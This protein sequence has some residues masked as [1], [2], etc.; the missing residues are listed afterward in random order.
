MVPGLGAANFSDE[1]PDSR[2]AT[3]LMAVK[4]KSLQK[5]F[6]SSF[7]AD[8]AF[9]KLET[10]T[11]THNQSVRNYYTKMMK[12]CK[13]ADQTMSGTTKFKTTPMYFSQSYSIH[14]WDVLTMKPALFCALPGKTVEIYKEVLTGLN[15]HA[16]NVGI[17]LNPQTILI[18]FELTAYNAFSYIYP[19][20]VVKGC[21]A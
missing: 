3:T 5:D 7:S 2:P 1:I 15:S 12:L 21:Y 18:D 11:Q 19:N 9:S 6:I 10:Y 8:I 13:E 17:I 20:A 4:L 14:V 16:S